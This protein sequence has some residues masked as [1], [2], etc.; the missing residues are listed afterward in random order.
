MRIGELAKAAGTSKDTVRHYVEL[1][2]LRAHK[3]PENGYQIFDG[4]ALSRLNFIKTARGLG[5][6]LPDIESI[7]ADAMHEQ[8][9]CPRVRQLMTKRIA[10]TREH[11]AK[12]SALCERMEQAIGEWRHMPD[13]VPNGESLCKLIESQWTEPSAQNHTDSTLGS[14]VE[15]NLESTNHGQ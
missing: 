14:D 8:S 15:M 5:L 1:G 3:N 13:S 7:F 9:P 10:A 6:S 4:I 11:I 2:L 12:L